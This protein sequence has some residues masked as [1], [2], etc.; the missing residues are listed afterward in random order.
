MGQEREHA[1]EKMIVHL[2]I[3]LDEPPG[4]Q[5]GTN[6]VSEFLEEGDGIWEVIVIICQLQGI[7]EER[8]FFSAVSG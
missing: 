4:S 3:Q 8:N 6:V 2:A 1:I 7:R 5:A